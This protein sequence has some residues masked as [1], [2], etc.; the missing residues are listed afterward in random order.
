M[1]KFIDELASHAKSK[2]PVFVAMRNVEVLELN[3]VAVLLS[4]MVKFK[5]SGVRFDG[6]FPKDKLAKKLLIESKFF[7]H[8]HSGRH[9]DRPEYRFDGASIFTHG[10]KSVDAALA[11]E[12]VDQVSQTVWGTKRRC[13]D[14]YRVFVELM[15]NTNNHASEKSSGVKHYWISVQHLKSENRVL[16][17]F[18]D[19]GVGIFE[20]LRS[21]TVADKFFEQVAFWKKEELSNSDFLRKIFEGE[22]RESS[23][24]EYFRGKGLPGVYNAIKCNGISNL[25]LIS[26]NVFYNS[27]EDSYTQLDRSFSGTLITWELNRKN[28]SLKSLT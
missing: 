2:T 6:D 15:L 23:T 26:N 9:K 22:L 7:H 1:A 4:V 12:I 14:L 20:H 17:T 10:Q 25:A 27:T 18:V 16:F 11:G 19:F 3:A 21:K 24:R 8:L 13:S 28:E 5:N